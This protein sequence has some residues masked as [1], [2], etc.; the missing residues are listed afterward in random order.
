MEVI[1]IIAGI[2]LALIIKGIYDNKKYNKKLL[3]RAVNEYGKE[4]K[5]E[6]TYARAEAIAYYS[7]HHEK[8]D[9]FVDDITWEDTDMPR[10]YGRL[11]SCKCAIG[12]EYLYY[13]LKNPTSSLE[14]LEERER[15]ITHLQKDEKSRTALSVMLLK[16]GSLKNI[17]AYEYVN[18]LRSVDIDSSA[19]H[20]IQALLLL[21]SIGLIF[22]TPVYGTL[23]T[24]LMFFVNV[25][26]YFKRKSLIEG[27]FTIVFFILRLLEQ[28]KELK[29]V[30]DPELKSYFDKITKEADNFNKMKRNSFYLGSSS[31]GNPL[32]LLFDYIKMAFHIDLIKFNM[33]L[34]EFSKHVDEFE[35]IFEIVGFLDCMIAVAS[36]RKLHED[37]Y[38]VPLLKVRSGQAALFINAKGL[39]HPL[40]NDPVTNDLETTGPVLLTGSNASGKSTFLKTIAL[41]AILAQSIHTVLAESY[42]GGMFK[43]MTSMALRDDIES[44]ES[45]YIVEIKSLKRI[46]DASKTSSIPVLC[47]IDE[48]LRGTNTVERIAASTQI[49]RGLGEANA[50]CM[51][52]THDIELTWLLEDIFDNYHFEEQILDNEIKFDYR[53]KTGRANS[54]NAISLLRIMGYST[55]TVEAAVEMAQRY[56]DTGE[57]KI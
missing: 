25:I 1:L 2:L 34:R 20:I 55:D 23:L 42:E 31:G 48:V 16:I 39:A 33:M 44:G 52:A 46:I 27:Y 28:A 19:L 17:S 50:L 9:C 4:P 15:V 43:V 14:K 40:L 11:N 30:D 7:A 22:I 45:Y 21:A 13:L 38:S 24:I 5:K 36:Y 53:L 32:E 54:R 35:A 49:L 12:E 47:F 41:N 29:K 3:D 10:I 37:D 51:A 8:S 26:T 56:V 57:W 18:R 6:I